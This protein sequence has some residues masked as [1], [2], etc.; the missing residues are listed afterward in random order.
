MP[1]FKDMLLG[2]GKEDDSTHAD[3]FGPDKSTDEFVQS[4]ADVL[5]FGADKE[6]ANPNT[7]KP[8]PSSAFKPSMSPRK[9]AA[10]E[11]EEKFQSPSRVA[12]QT[13]ESNGFYPFSDT[14]GKQKHRGA[15][16]FFSPQR[17]EDGRV[18][19]SQSNIDGPSAID[20]ACLLKD[21]WGIK[22]NGAFQNPVNL[23]M[24]KDR[25]IVSFD[26]RRCW[27]AAQNSLRVPYIMHNED[28]VFIDPANG[29]KHKITENK[30]G[31]RRFKTWGD[32]IW[33][34]C[35]DHRNTEG[36]EGSKEL[37]TLRNMNRVPKHQLEKLTNSPC[38]QRATHIR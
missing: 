4:F 2:L 32:A 29:R 20:L 5:K 17:G 7:G 21:G 10:T 13:P 38:D 15:H 35:N 28:D 19:F 22:P 18:Y 27:A 11:M 37:P 6:N 24:F 1:S 30:T 25:S 26:H 16:G 34:R 36:F 12:G 9:Q 14:I 23:V 3:A 8:N 31:R 33:E